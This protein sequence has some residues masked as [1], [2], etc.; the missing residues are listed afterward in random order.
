MLAD[1]VVRRGLIAYGIPLRGTAVLAIVVVNRRSVSGTRKS[2]SEIASSV[3]V[4]CHRI[5]SRRI[6]S[7]PSALWVL[8]PYGRWA[9]R[10]C[11]EFKYIE[12]LVSLFTV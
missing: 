4:A 11:I 3:D 8:A 7:L 9:I 6:A 1:V 12:R 10:E 2:S 5:G